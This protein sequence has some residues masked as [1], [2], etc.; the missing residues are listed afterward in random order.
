M[1]I[2]TIQ[3]LNEVP[4]YD[5]LGIATHPDLPDLIAI[6]F[7]DKEGKALG[8]VVMNLNTAESFGKRFFAKYN[9]LL[10]AWRESKRHGKPN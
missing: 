3:S 1:D 10:I 8:Q 7:H 4:A 6:T 9:D 5:H 2:K